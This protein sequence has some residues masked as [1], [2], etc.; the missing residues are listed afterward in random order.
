MSDLVAE[1]IIYALKDALNAAGG[2]GAIVRLDPVSGRLVIDG[3]FD[4]KVV[5]NRIV[6]DLNMMAEAAQ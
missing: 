5:A 3:V 1:A 4:L 6:A 2:P